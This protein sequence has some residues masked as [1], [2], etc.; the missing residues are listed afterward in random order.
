MSLVIFVLKNSIIISC[1]KKSSCG[2]YDCTFINQRYYHIYQIGL[3]KKKNTYI[4][5]K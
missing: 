5:N 3:T 2:L 4:K 1:Y